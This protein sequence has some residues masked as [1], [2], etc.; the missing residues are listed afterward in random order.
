VSAKKKS[1]SRSKMCLMKASGE[2]EVLNLLIQLPL[3][4]NGHTRKE[5]L[6]NVS[7]ETLDEA[8]KKGYVKQVECG[9]TGEP[10]P[11]AGLSVTRKGMNYLARIA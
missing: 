9:C 3:V 7:D 10:E 6:E 1:T 5:W 11:G 4:N 8:I 2:R